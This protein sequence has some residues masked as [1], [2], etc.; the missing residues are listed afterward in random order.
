MVCLKSPSTGETDAHNH[1]R[2]SANVSGKITFSVPFAPFLNN[3][4]RRITL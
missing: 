3:S 1:T 4:G 2:W